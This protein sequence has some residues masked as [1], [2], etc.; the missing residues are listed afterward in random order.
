MFGIKLAIGAA[1]STTGVIRNIESRL[2]TFSRSV[3]TWMNL[4]GLVQVARRVGNALNSAFEASTYSKEWSRLKET[5]S[6]GFS[7]LGGRIADSWGPML[8]GVQKFGERLVGWFDVAIDKLQWMGAAMGALLGGASFKEASN[9]ADATV[10]AMKKEREERKKML[11]AEDA[12]A[13]KDDSRSRDAYQRAREQAKRELEMLKESGGDTSIAAKTPAT[14][15]QR[16][17]ARQAE[18]QANIEASKTRIGAA[19]LKY[20][21]PEGLGAGNYRASAAGDF[22]AGIADMDADELQ[23]LAT[24][25]LSGISRVGKG[26]RAASRQ[27]RKWDRLLNEAR[28]REARGVRLSSRMQAVLA[29]DRKRDEEDRASQRK[30]NVEQAII[31]ME[32]RVEQIAQEL[33]GTVTGGVQ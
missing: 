6:S 12:A 17:L 33:L 23:A 10:A 24:G 30:A 32:T 20:S 4:G 21:T 9:I 19:F 28:G 16:A 29:A 5:L 25:S 3:M 13:K 7:S 8:D 1:D 22:A 27:S 18:L 26:V 15:E 31:D 2:K 11:A 14:M